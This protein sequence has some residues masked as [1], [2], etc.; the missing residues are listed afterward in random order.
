ME[1]ENLTIEYRWAQGAYYQL[2]APG[3]G[4]GSPSGRR[5]L[6]RAPQAAGAAKA[7]TATIP[8]SLQA[9]QSGRIGLLS[10]LSRPGGN[11]TRVSFLST[12]STAKRLKSLRQLV[13]NAASI[14]FLVNPSRGT[15]YEAET[16]DTKEGAQTFGLRLYV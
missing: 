4:F 10:S 7:A 9:E 3:E 13:P 8:S 6:C 2:P 14:G 11:A 15:S 1:G 16:K 12:R 5:D